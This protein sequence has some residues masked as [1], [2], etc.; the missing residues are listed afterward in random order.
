MK[1][2]APAVLAATMALTGCTDA[3]E[4]SDTVS[5]STI[6]YDAGSAE[7]LA[8]PSADSGIQNVFGSCD[9]ERPQVHVDLQGA[10]DG[11]IKHAKTAGTIYKIVTI[12]M[13]LASQPDYK[14]DVGIDAIVLYALGEKQVSLTNAAKFRG[15]L[16]D[17]KKAV[18][19]TSLSFKACA[20]AES[21]DVAPQA[22]DKVIEQAF[23]E[24]QK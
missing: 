16:Y 22:C 11:I 15:L 5:K 8:R 7:K 6:S 1:Q 2:Y 14:G 23:K 13:A 19:E 4:L 17:A 10:I 9:Y 12:G 3:P 24:M 18:D 20:V 21:L